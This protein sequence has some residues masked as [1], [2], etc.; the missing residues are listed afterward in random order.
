[1]VAHIYLCIMTSFRISIHLNQR[2]P[3]EIE[4]NLNFYH[5]AKGLNLQ[6]QLPTSS[7][8]SKFKLTIHLLLSYP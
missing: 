7:Y 6:I 4:L 2:F 5:R 8:V 3:G 1:M